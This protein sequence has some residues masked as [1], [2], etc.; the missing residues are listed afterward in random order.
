MVFWRSGLCVCRVLT[1]LNRNHDSI[2]DE[3][4]A[5]QFPTNRRV[6]GNKAIEKL[7]IT[8]LAARAKF[9]LSGS[10]RILGLARP[11]FQGGGSLLSAGDGGAEG[12]GALDLW[13]KHTSPTNGLLLTSTTRLAPG[14]RLSRF[15]RRNLHRCRLPIWKRSSH[16][17]N[18]AGHSSVLGAGC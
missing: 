5:G 10:K 1:S 3:P 17:A 18:S 13:L 11:P 14:T 16:K 15:L 12:Q 4:R 7:Q 2:R 6:K 8:P 9:L